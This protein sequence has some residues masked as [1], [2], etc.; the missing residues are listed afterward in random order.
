MKKK[1]DDYIV[2]FYILFGRSLLFHGSQR[3][4][5][6]KRNRRLGIMVKL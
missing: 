1:V 5:N 2:G 6:S 3:K 4:E